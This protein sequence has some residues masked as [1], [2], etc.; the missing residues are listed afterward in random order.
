MNRSGWDYRDRGRWTIGPVFVNY[1]RDTPLGFPR[2]T[3]WGVTMF[4][5]TRNFTRGTDAVDTPGR[6]GIR[7]WYR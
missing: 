5:W 2:I 3:S 6:G 1:V 7:R 4:G